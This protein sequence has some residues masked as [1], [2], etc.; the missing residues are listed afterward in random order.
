MKVSHF[1]FKRLC[2]S[3][4]PNQSIIKQLPC[5]SINTFLLNKQMHSVEERRY[6]FLV[7]LHE[8]K[9]KKKKKKNRIN[10]PTK[11]L[12][13]FILQIYE[14]FIS[15]FSEF[16]ISQYSR[17]SMWSYLLSLK[18]NQESIRIGL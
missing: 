18:A 15:V 10:L 12:V 16:D 9:K 3:V 2:H 5:S 6:T 8:K 1:P 13:Q 17:N 14:T 4:D 7:K 11:I